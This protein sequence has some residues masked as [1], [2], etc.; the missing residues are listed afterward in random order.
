[1]PSLTPEQIEKIVEVRKNGGS[2]REAARAAGCAPSTVGQ[3][4]P[5][6]KLKIQESV[7]QEDNL[8]SLIAVL[9]K[10]DLTLEEIAA[11]GNVSKECAAAWIAF[12]Q[13]KGV[14]ICLLDGHYG[15]EN[16][17]QPSSGSVFEFVSDRNNVF[18]FGASGDQHLCSKYERLDV[19]NDLYDKYEDAGIKKVF[20]TGNWIDGEARFNRF[21]LKVHGMGRQLAYLAEHYPRRQGITTWAVSGDDHEGWYGQREG[22]DIGKYAEYSMQEAGRND[23]RHL[24]FI[25][26]HIRLVN[27]NTGKSSFMTV[28]HP[29]G[30]SAYAIS[31][32]PQKLVESLG[33]GEKPAVMLLGHY[34]KISANNIRNVWVVQTGCTQ[35]QTTF[36]KKNRIEAHVGGFIIKMHQD[37]ETGAITRFVN[38]MIRYFDKGYYG[39]KRWSYDGDVELPVRM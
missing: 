34:H 23:W 37:P 24:G 21:D 14:N 26:A 12:Q 4:C 17:P 36:M 8:E 19:L 28:M 20:N 3:Y 11:Y 9:R 29:G 6:S 16:I 35:D 31:Y 25:E 18:H 13:A 22:V 32:Q 7:S 38:E 27:A 33:G 39:N 1:L 10:S 2:Y 30:G 15:I 5:D